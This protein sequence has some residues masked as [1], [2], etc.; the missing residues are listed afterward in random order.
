M[1]HQSRRLSSSS[2][3]AGWACLASILGTVPARAGEPAPV[4]SAT[5][6]A[7]ASTNADPPDAVRIAKLQIE[8]PDGYFSKQA[9]QQEVYATVAADT[10]DH[11]ISSGD[12]VWV[13]TDSIDLKAGKTYCIAVVGLTEPADTAHSARLPSSRYLGTYRVLE[14][15][16]TAE[17]ER[18]CRSG[19]LRAALRNFADAR[20][21]FQVEGIERT[22]AVGGIR[23][24]REASSTRVAYESVGLSDSG[25]NSIVNSLPSEFMAAFDYR[26]LQWLFMGVSATFDDQVVCFAV[27]GVS[28]TSPDARNV[29]FPGTWTSG[30]WEM[31]AE[32]SRGPDAAQRCRDE[33]TLNTVKFA[34]ENTWDEQGLLKNLALTKEADL[35]L[36]RG[37][38]RVKP[39]A[40]P[41]RSEAILASAAGGGATCQPPTGKVLRYSDR[42]YNGDCTRTFENGCSKR[43][44]APY[45]YDALEGRWDWKPDGC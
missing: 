14:P 25:M 40:A 4:G 19:A 41:P 24:Q 34:L 39:K 26:R 23:P 21:A 16:P 31:S 2:L 28:A 17:S 38:Q 20:L 42:C 22:R 45:C 8:S 6:T 35:P 1:K 30:L 7:P 27:V 5:P 3:A 15:S 32:Q 11:L 33:R 12:A 29:R 9:L 10:R 44:R 36:V 43:F 13:F 18:D 37:Y